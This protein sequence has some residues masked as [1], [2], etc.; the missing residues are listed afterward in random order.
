MQSVTRPLLIATVLVATHGV[1]GVQSASAQDKFAAIAYSES[2]HTYGY[3]YKFGSRAAAEQAAVRY[4]KTPDAESKVWTRNQWC[5]LALDLDGTARGWG[6]HAT[7]A[8]AKARAFAECQRFCDNCYVAVCVSAGGQVMEY[9][10]PMSKLASM[11][12]AKPLPN[13]PVA[14]FPSELP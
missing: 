1:I 9:D 5:A 14:F 2:K 11:P 13:L 12:K 7:A 6:W 10:P 3:S 8:G 4:C